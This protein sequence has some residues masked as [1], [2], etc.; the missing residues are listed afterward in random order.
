MASKQWLLRLTVVLAAIVVAVVAWRVYA[1]GSRL[2]DN[3][4]AVSGRIE[5]DDSAIASKQPGRVVSVRYR[6]GDSVRAGD[7]IATLDDAQARA[8]VADA[9]A[10]LQA[11]TRQT[12]VM[13]AQLRQAQ[14]S[15]GQAE[16]VVT[17]GVSQAESQY[18]AARADLTR[19]E[20]AYRLAEDDQRRAV[21][22]Y[23]SGD[24]AQARRDQ[25]VSTAQQTGAAVQAAQQQVDAAQAVLAQARANEAEPPIRQQ[26]ANAA[27]A[28][29][30]TQNATIRAASAQL[31]QAEANLQD[32]T[33]RAPF[34]GT[35]MVRAVEPGEV[36]AAGTPIV[37]LLNLDKVYLR[38][39]VP[40][41]Q[42]GR[43]AIGQ[44]ARVFLDSDPAHPLDA[45]VLRIDPEAMFT[46]ENTYFRS[47]RVKEV[48]G[49]KLALR[50]GFG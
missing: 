43:V 23:A 48:F 20:S 5:G 12:S 21:A 25:A 47:D 14:L 35:V 10:R 32:L 31:Q 30:N 33:V 4:I 13:D 39:F 38:A 42:I 15:T 49:V 9:R 22:L 36:L 50:T 8:A 37:T 27:A 34:N 19:A 28:Q 26:Q 41:E 2:P 1:A 18:A 11:A 3:V 29:I 46:P 16:G 45:Y 6:E 7:V 17:G 24:I 44:P 40:E